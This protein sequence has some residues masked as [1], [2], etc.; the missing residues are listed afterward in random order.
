METRRKRLDGHV[1]RIERNRN[2]YRY[3]VENPKERS[4]LEELDI[5]GIVI[6]KDVKEMDYIQLAEDRDK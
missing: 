5:D 1:S 2:A 4:H 6:F 3:L